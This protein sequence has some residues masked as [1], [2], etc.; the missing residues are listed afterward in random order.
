[1]GILVNGLMSLGPENSYLNK[2]KLIKYAYSMC[3]VQCD[4]NPELEL[5]LEN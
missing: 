1:M 2:H 4:M 3:G 5:T